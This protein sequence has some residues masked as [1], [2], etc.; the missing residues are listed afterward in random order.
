MVFGLLSMIFR[1]VCTFQINRNRVLSSQAWG[2]TVPQAAVLV[3]HKGILGSAVDSVSNSAWCQPWPPEYDLQD[4]RG[5]KKLTLV[6]CLWEDSKQSWHHE[7][8]NQ[9][10]NSFSFVCIL[11]N[12]ETIIL[13]LL[14]LSFLLLKAENN[15]T[16]YN[17]EALRGIKKADTWRYLSLPR[18]SF[19]WFQIINIFFFWYICMCRGQRQVSGFIPL[20]SFTFLYLFLRQG[21]W[22]VW[23]SPRLGY[24]GWS[25]FPRVF[26]SLLPQTWG[27]KWTIASG[28][29]TWALGIKFWSSLRQIFY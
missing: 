4:Q 28:I 18:F 1:E 19:P 26:R 24:A 17:V 25:M 6:N 8:L 14:T 16:W 23:S 21:L 12:K 9:S 11:W 5:R 22:L 29:F 13:K 7:S 2:D 15:S 3:S 10:Q 20:V 27:Y